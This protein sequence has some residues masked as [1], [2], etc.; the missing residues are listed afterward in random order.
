MLIIL[1][2][3]FQHRFD[4]VPIFRGIGNLSLE[5]LYQRDEIYT[6]G[7]H[8]TWYLYGPKPHIIC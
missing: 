3:K 2:L 4:Y 7:E 8:A 5:V 1:N 6:G